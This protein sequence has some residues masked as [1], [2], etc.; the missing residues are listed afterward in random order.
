MAVG[1]AL[2]SAGEDG[3]TAAEIGFIAQQHQ[4]N[5]KKAAEELVNE[6][7]LRYTDP[8][9][10]NG[11]RGRRPRVAFAFAA[12]ERQRFEEMVADENLMGLLGMGTQL[13]MVDAEDRPERLSEVLS[14]SEVVSDAAWAAHVE[15]GRSEVWLAY[16]GYRAPDD[17][18]DLMAILHAAELTARRGSVAK[19]ANARDLARAEERKK[20]RVERARSRLQAQ[21]PTPPPRPSH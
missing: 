7:A 16:E 21:R 19:L 9:P 13:V 2:L 17:S 20:Q 3:M 10:A 18:R 11:R 6:G 1:R 4:S 5:L 15:G 12:G 8:P 14:Q